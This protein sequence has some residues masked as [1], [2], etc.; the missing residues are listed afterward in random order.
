M[1]RWN[2]K[3]PTLIILSCLIFIMLLIVVL[4]DV[5][6]PDT[7]FHQ[8]T[9]PLVVHARGTTAPPVVAVAALFQFPKIAHVRRPG[10]ELDVVFAHLDPNFRPILFRSIRR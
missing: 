2:V 1:S 8:G 5:D 7:A 9:A 4:P 10:R 3:A 6:L